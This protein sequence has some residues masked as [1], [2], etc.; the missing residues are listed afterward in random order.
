ME[1]ENSILHL[2][3]HKIIILVSIG[4]FKTWKSYEKQFFGY[5]IC[6]VVIAYLSQRFTGIQ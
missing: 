3:M 5:V 1:P 2:R 4:F 6:V